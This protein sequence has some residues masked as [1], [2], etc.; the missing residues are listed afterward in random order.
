MKRVVVLVVLAAL[1]TLGTTPQAARAGGFQLNEQGARAMALA[2]AAASGDGAD[3]S[4][5]FYNPAG[6]TQMKDG[7][8]LMLGLTP[9]LPQAT[10]TGP[11][12]QNRFATTNMELWAFPLPHAYA[13]YKVPQSDLAFGLGVFVP[14]GAGTLWNENWTGRNLAVRTYLQTITINPNVA[15]AFFD[16]KLSIAAGLTYSIGHAELRQRVPNF[17]TEPFLNLRGDGTNISWNA[18]LSVEPVKGLR[19]GASYRHNINMRYDGNAKFTLDAAGNTPLPAGLNNLFADGPG[20]T[21]L[22][23]PFDLRTGI[24]YRF[25]DQFM[26]ELGIDYVGWSSYDT[27][28]IRFDRL[29]GAPSRSGEVINP[30]NYY[31]TPTFRIGGEYT[32]SETLQLRAGAFYDV[33]PVEA[34]Y[35]QPI[36][37]DANRIAVTAGAGFKLSD[38]LTL[39]VSYMFVYGLQREVT[40]ST[41]GFDGIYN[42][43]ANALAFS[44]SYRL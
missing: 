40:G 2:F 3:A 35:T 17:G 38:N 36:L 10:F 39:D 26:M 32:A 34:R 25:S 12:N 44:F 29:P 13:V 23:L 22:N 37:P 15:Y 9:L 18:A 14:F 8:H 5:V 31:N 43:W 16:K 28:R 20:G 30:R 4:T 42:S 7:L 6:M 33:V 24:S 19:I 27:L 1:V 41:F 21:A 11:T